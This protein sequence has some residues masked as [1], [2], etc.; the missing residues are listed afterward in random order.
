MSN[1][2]EEAH[3]YLKHNFPSKFSTWTQLG[4][5]RRPPGFRE[6]D[7]IGVVNL[8]LGKLDD[9]TILPVAL[10]ACTTLDAKILV[11]GVVREDGIREKLDPGTLAT[12]VGAKDRVFCATQKARLDILT[13][14]GLSYACQ[15]MDSRCMRAFGRVLEKAIR[16]VTD[17]GRN[18]HVPKL[19]DMF[20]K[21]L[22]DACYDCRMEFID[23]ELV[24]RIR[25]WNRLPELVLGEDFPDWDKEPDGSVN[26]LSPLSVTFHLPLL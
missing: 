9:H 8:A 19:C 6:S 5:T 18:P 7:A 16:N 14:D 13:C 21:D 17:L 15:N 22:K 3:G 26:V 2:Y 25:L 23:T 4:V 10:L 11:E 1:I 20:E 12:C 24:E